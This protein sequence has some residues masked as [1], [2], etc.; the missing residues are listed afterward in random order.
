MLD[1]Y[2]FGDV[3][4]ISPEAPVPVVRI[5]QFE[6]R[7]GGAANVA[8]NVASLGAHATLVAIV[9]NDEP[10]ELIAR[11]AG[12]LGVELRL[13]RD[14]DLPTTIKLRVIGRQQQL[15]R[16]DFEESPGPDALAAKLDAVREAI[17][18][19]DVM[20]LS[21]YGKGGLAQVDRMLA[22]AR[23]AGKPVVVDPKGEDFDRYRGASILTPNRAELRA[24][25]GSWQGEEDLA[26]KAHALRE[27]LE[28]DALLVTRSEEGMSLFS[29]DGSSRHVAARAR[30]VYDVSGA[31]DTVVA[32]LATALAVGCPLAVAMGLANTAGGI[33]VGKLGTA[34]VTPEELFGS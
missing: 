25:V 33:V 3:E 21:D 17:D 30:E 28:L 26:A 7:L 14:A 31:G 32:T 11:M 18:A 4:R 20:V 34:D 27:R 8:R 15:L 9:G 19:C 1:R 23:E 13:A 2:W 10:G 5:R 6:E 29:R 24:V 12:E 22:I 16:I